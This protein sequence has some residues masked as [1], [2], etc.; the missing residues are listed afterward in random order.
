MH[1]SYLLSSWSV[2]WKGKVL[3]NQDILI[4][5]VFERN[6]CIQYFNQGQGHFGRMSFHLRTSCLK[7][8]DLQK[9]APACCLVCLVECF[10]YYMKLSLI[11]KVLF[12]KLVA[13]NT[14][15]GITIP[16]TSCLTGL[17]SAVWQLTFSV[18]ISKT[19]YSKPVK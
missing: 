7:P 6:R 4:K 2:N 15:G 5:F 17:E 14:K 13:G 1:H 12:C 9:L 19:D 16:L 11:L 10:H 8:F 3:L 18:F